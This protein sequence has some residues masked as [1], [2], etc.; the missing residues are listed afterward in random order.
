MQKDGPVAPLT[1]ERQGDEFGHEASTQM[2][3]RADLLQCSDFPQSSEEPVIGFTYNQGAKIQHARS[4]TT[5]T[6]RAARLGATPL[7]RLP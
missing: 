6:L 7:T 3:T 4:K 2:A 5:Y 1:K